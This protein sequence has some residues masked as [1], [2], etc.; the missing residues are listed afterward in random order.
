MFDKRMK[1]K[2]L[3]IS[4]QVLDGTLEHQRVRKES[5]PGLMVPAGY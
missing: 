5:D 4:F 3:K 1:A 2:Y